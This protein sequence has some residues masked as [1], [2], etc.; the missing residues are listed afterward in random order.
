MARL[1]QMES[2]RR[3]EL[4]EG[5]PWAEKLL[6]EALLFASSGETVAALEKLEELFSLWNEVEEL[7]QQEIR[8]SLAI[9]PLFGPLRRHPALISMLYRHLGSTAPARLR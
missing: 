3:V 9:D 7:T 6:G 5:A 4:S 8:I 2:P 1:G